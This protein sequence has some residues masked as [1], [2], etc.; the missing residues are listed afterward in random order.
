MS[1]M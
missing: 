1:V